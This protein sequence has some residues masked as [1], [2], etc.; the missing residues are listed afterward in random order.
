MGLTM[1]HNKQ[2]NIGV[3][4]EI[5]NHAVLTAVSKNDIPRAQKL[6]SLLRENFVKPTEISKAYKIYSQFLYSEARNP[7]FASKFIENLKKE[8]SKT[9]KHNKLNAELASLMENINKT[10]DKKR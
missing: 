3:L 4:F 5:L 9:I 7:Y 2:K 10:T 6:F 1:K 8:Y